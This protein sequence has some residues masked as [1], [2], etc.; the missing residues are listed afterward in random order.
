MS[1]NEIAEKSSSGVSLIPTK[2]L[3]A[4]INS[5]GPILVHLFNSCISLNKIPDA[6]KHAECIP[7]HKKGSMVDVNNYR[8]ISILPPIAKLF[9]KLIAQQIRSY[10]EN[11][12]L[13]FA[14]QH[15]F[16]K[17]FSCESALHELLSDL[18]KNQEKKLIS[19]LLFIDYR[20]A[21]DLISLKLLIRKLFHYGFNNDALD[22]VK[23]YFTNRKQ[24]IKIQDI[25]SDEVDIDL[26][27]PQGSVLGPLFF[28][29]FIN[30]L[31]FIMELLAKLF[32]DDTTF[33]KAGKDINQLISTFVKDL[34]PLLLWCRMNKLD[35]NFKKTYFMIVTRHR[36]SL[37]KSIL[38]N[39]IEIEVVDRFKLLGV[40]LDSKLIFSSYVSSI[41]G[42]VNSIL[43]SI[44]RLFYLPLS[45]K[46]QFFKTFILPLFDYCLTLSI[47]YEKYLITK[48][49]N[50]Y[51][52][53][54]SRLFGAN[55]SDSFNF[56]NKS[57]DELQSFL[58]QYNLCSFTHRLFIRLDLFIYKIINSSTPPILNECMIVDTSDNI[59]NRLKSRR[60]KLNYEPHFTTGFGFKTFDFFSSIFYNNFLLSKRHISLFSFKSDLYKNLGIYH[61]LFLNI[62]PKFNIPYL[63]KK[64]IKI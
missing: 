58:S 23:C 26:G 19:I 48:L 57:H 56:Y 47:Y 35:I 41:C 54:M 45:T 18:N 36:V 11:N 13:F 8:G 42:R 22:L 49:S 31:P 7:L 59:A 4:S 50:C 27:V 39:G 43:Y 2:I 61:H 32:A 1:L 53:T 60:K 17:H 33:Y 25:F 51:Y 30:D 38:V 14:G 6:F 52:T 28:L 21:F 24:H 3:K 20:K 5:I 64:F 34:E 9:E 15:G 46:V 37:P 29:I 55:K 63:L 62:F 44:K 40:T 10:F 12:K 16:R